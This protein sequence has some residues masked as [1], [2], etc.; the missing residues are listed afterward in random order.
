[1]CMFDVA[2]HNITVN[3]ADLMEEIHKMAAKCKTVQSQSFNIAKL[4]SKLR[5][6]GY[7]VH[8][9]AIS[10]SPFVNN[11]IYE[12]NVKQEENRLNSKKITFYVHDRFLYD[13]VMTRLNSYLDSNPLPKCTDTIVCDLLIAFAARPAELHNLK[14]LDDNTIIG[15]DKSKH[16][17]PRPYMGMFP[18]EESKK[19]LRILETYKKPSLHQFHET[20]RN[21]YGMRPS[22]FRKL[23]AEYIT[24]DENNPA[25]RRM[26]KKTA[27]RHSTPAMSLMHYDI[28][29]PARLYKKLEDSEDESISYV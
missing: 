1:M 9:E 2:Y 10:K 5:D 29:D 11:V 24:C 27:L 14:V 23:G 20:I 15:Y 4:K 18:I 16:G 17:I 12:S 19:L 25:R 6:N 22:Q 7:T 26:L 28:E 3:G 8:V 13:N 21:A